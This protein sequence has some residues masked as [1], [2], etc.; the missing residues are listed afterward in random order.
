MKLKLKMKKKIVKENEVV[1]IALN[2]SDKFE[3]LDVTVEQGHLIA[4]LLIQDA[5]H[6][7]TIGFDMFFIF[8]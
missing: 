1:H 2:E 3:A 8:L 7:R 4:A 6:L 5:K